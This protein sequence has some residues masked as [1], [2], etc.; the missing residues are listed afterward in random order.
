MMLQK[1]RSLAGI[2]RRDPGEFAQ[3]VVAIAQ[4]RAE[5]L[6]VR[7]GQ[8]APQ[9]AAALGA[10]LAPTLGP[11]FAAALEEPALQE[12]ERAVR[13]RLA[14]LMPRA[15]YTLAHNAD[16]SLA[17]CCYAVCRAVDARSVVETGVG[18]GVTT[19]FLLAALRENGGGVLYSIDLPPLE[20]GAEETVGVLVPPA[21]RREWKLQR[22]MS[23]QLLPSL[24]ARLGTID[25]F[26]H[27]SLHTGDNM[28][29]EF[30]QAWPRIRAGGVLLADD[31]EGNDAF[32]EVRQRAP[33][34]WG[35]FRQAEKPSLFGVAV[36]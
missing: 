18:Y 11:A 28:R 29:F 4:G 8:Y 5:P 12:T 7:R 24:L 33:R 31:V 13:D 10:L 14:D 20:P 6:R 2:L 3:R 17:H 15:P 21:L 34:A 36:A 23:R 9:P 1:V 26:L 35:V 22:G 27:D 19:A 25:L 32:G 30:A 16:F